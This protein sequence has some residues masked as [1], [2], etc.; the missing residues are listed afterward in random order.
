MKRQR[1]QDIKRY[2]DLTKNEQENLQHVRHQ[3]LQAQKE[4]PARL[5]EHLQAFNDAIIAIIMTII[6]LE[7]KPPIDEIRY[8]DFLRD[9]LIFLISFFI[10]ADFWYELHIA[11]SYFIIKPDKKTVVADFFLLADLSLLPILTKWIMAEQ[12]SFAVINFG[13]VFFI[14]QILKIITQYFG[15]KP[16]MKDSKI[17][18]ILVMHESGRRLI[19]ALVWNL[20]LIVLAIIQPQIAMILYLTI[21]IASF[22]TQRKR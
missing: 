14:A 7:I 4:D 2:R 11:F 9:I 17:M 21:P 12:S 8:V 10:I 19:F 3:L 1:D 20:V 13:V 22:L 18:D 16:T 5:R 15:T 6:V